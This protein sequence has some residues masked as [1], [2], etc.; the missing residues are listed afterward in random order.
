VKGTYGF[1]ETDDP[2]TGG[3]APGVLAD[4]GNVPETVNP[5]RCRITGRA[6]C[7]AGWGPPGSCPPCGGAPAGPSSRRGGG[8]R[9]GLRPFAHRRSAPSPQLSQRLGWQ[10]CR[11]GADF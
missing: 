3:L 2:R 10:S 9:G 8:G 7:L 6:G 1:R 11:P 4:T 5:E